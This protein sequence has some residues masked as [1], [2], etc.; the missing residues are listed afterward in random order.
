[1][2]IALV[3]PPWLACP[4]K[5]YG[6]IEWVVAL[7]ADGLAE[8]GHDVTLF[9]TGDSVT[10]ARLEWVF[11]EAPG[12]RF[13]NDIL[14]DTLH[15]LR[16]FRDPSRFDVF[17]VHSPFSALAVAACLPVPAVHTIHGSFTEPMRRIYRE[18]GDRVWYVAI[19]HSQRSHMPDLHYGGV[20]Y[21]GVDVDA[22][23]FRAEK[24]GF[25]LFLGRAA[26][27]KG[28]L[29]AVLAAREAGVPLVLAVKVA[30]RVEEE[31]WARDV[32]P[33]LPEGTQ[34]LGEVSL[35]EKLD[36]LSRA[37]AVLFPIDWDE[38][39]GL[40][41][42][43]AM[44]CGTPVIATPRGAAPEVVADGVTGFL[45]SVEDYPREAARAIERLGEIDPSGCRAR[46]K[47][48]FSKEAMV[49]GYERV[50]ELAVAVR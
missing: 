40:V 6:G 25:V 4:P 35:E 36:L 26:P 7:L 14:L 2:R 32:V 1:M 9:A 12:P 31:H 45:V 19:S 43:E 29:R 38:P 50:Y 13:I 42:A 11:P 3:A 10:K 49:A 44:A 48:L 5:G 27:E 18:A 37:R 39:F 30:D 47:E 24:E 28:V 34:V 16:A 22:Y 33:N 17:H 15:T 8:R 21:N 23:P 20:V 46:V 41:M